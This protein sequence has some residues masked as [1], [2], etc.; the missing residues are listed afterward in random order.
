MKLTVLGPGCWGLTIAKLE[1]NNFDEICV[2][3]RKEDI[4]DELR[5][6]KKIEK[7]LKIELDKKI[8]ITDDGKVMIASNNIDDCSKAKEIIDS[9]LFEP[10]VGEKYTG[11]V[12]RIMPFGVFVE[13]TANVDG[14]IHISKLS[15]KHVEKVEDVV[16][17]GDRVEVEVIKIDDK[18][19]VDLK[20]IKK[21]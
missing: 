3:G 1:N 14:M 2:W 11:T 10:A 20:L 21:L 4:S 18:G 8:D 19:R 12:I 17:I 13:L 7:P 9:I 5:Y 15:E 6:E 16:A